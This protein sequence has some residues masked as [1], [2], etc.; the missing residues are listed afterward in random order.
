MK[1]SFKSA[2]AVCALAAGCTKFL[3][4]P[5]ATLDRSA[6]VEHVWNDLDRQY[7]FFDLKSVNWD[8]LHSV[9]VLRAAQVQSDLDLADIVGAMLLE[10]RD[11]HVNLFVGLR[12]YRYSGYDARPACFDSMVV[13]DRYVTDLRS[14]PRGRLQF[15]HATAEI[16]YVRIRSMSGSGFGADLDLVLEQLAGARAL[17]VDVRHNGGGQTRNGL[18]VAG[19][20]A[21]SDVSFGFVQYRD[22]PQHDDFTPLEA[23]VVSS[24]GPRRFPGPVAVLT[25][26]QS[27][28]ATELFVLAMRSLP[29]V[30][31][32]GDSTAGGVS[33]PLTRELPNGWTYRFS[34]SLWYTADRLTF[35]D[36]GLAPDVWVR[37]SA[38]E[39]AMGRDAVLDTAMA[40]VGA[41]LR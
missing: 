33:A 13:A 12:V 6:V 19:R 16:G 11:M 29:S 22:G 17:V 37:G 39:L 38:E 18:D 40:V 4:G 35:E 34:T 41:R 5:D 21:G 28:S 9:Y 31:I 20:F 25:N 3:V 30:V 8:S 1:R 10:L 26:R 23:Q 32:V 36:V 7:P 2:V 24:A 14:T 15:G 27:M